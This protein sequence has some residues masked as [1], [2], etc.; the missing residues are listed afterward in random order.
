NGLLNF[1]VLTTAN[2]S[3]PTT[4]V[5]GTFNGAPNSTFTLQFFA[6]TTSDPSGFGEGQTF[7]GSTTATTNGAGDAHVRAQ[8]PRGVP[9]GHVVTA[10]ATD[11]ARN[12]SEF[13]RAVTVQALAA[14]TAAGMPVTATEGVPFTPTVA[15]FTHGDTTRTAGDFTATI[16][17]GDGSSD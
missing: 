1:P 5:A 14:F 3:G 7:L 13:S 11:G 9:A 10:T 8:M 17:W 12:T 2:S 6:N 4:D 16:S 15:T